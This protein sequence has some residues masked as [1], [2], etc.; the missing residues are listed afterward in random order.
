M[1]RKEQAIKFHDMGYNCAQAVLMAFQDVIEMPDKVAMLKVS[2]GFGG[3][4]G[5]TYGTCGALSGAIMLAGLKN[6]DG[7]L[8]APRS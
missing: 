3:G 6:A 8:E 5:T 1:D 7:N 4:M 2:E